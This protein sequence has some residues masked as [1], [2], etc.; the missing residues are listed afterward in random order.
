MWK[1]RAGVGGARFTKVGDTPFRPPAAG[2]ADPHRENW[3][4]VGVPFRS[5]VQAAKRRMT[6]AV[7]V[8][9]RRSQMRRTSRFS[10][11][12]SVLTSATPDSTAVRRDSIPVRRDLTSFK[13]V[14]HLAGKRLDLSA[15]LDDDV[16]AAVDSISRTTV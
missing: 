14:S 2:C 1:S 5:A 4:E 15:E 12:T 13:V 9:I 16:V 8:G 10:T 3:P 11:A 7:N 6:T